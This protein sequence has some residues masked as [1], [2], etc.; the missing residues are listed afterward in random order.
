MVARRL[1]DESVQPTDFAFNN[2]NSAW[3]EKRIGLY[4]PGRQQSAVIPLLMRAQEQEGWISR[5]AIETIAEMLDMPYIRVLEVATF[6]TQFQLQPVGTNAHIQVCGTTPCMLRGAEDIRAV[7]QK[8][9]HPD[10]H[11]TNAAGTLSWEEVECMGACVNAPMIA[12]GQDT[13]EDLT[14]ERMEEIIDAFAEGR[15]DSIPPGTQ[16]DRVFAAPVEGRTTLLEEPTAERQKFVPPEPE[17]E[18]QAPPAEPQKPAAKTEPKKD[19]VKPA[20]EQEPTTAA[21]PHDVTAESAPAVK[22]PSAEAK[23]S[24]AE[25]EEEREEADDEAGADGTTSETMRE[26][27]HGSEEPGGKAD[28]GRAV[29]KPTHGEP[30]EGGSSAGVGSSVPSQAPVEGTPEVDP[31]AEEG[32]NRQLFTP[33]QGPAD[34]LK[35]INGIGPAIETKLNETGITRFSQIA[36]LSDDDVGTLNKA[37]SVQGRIE[38]DNWIEQAKVLE[39]GGAEEHR[40]VF[41]KDTKS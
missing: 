4:P 35:L 26:G 37:L 5:S 23:V 13:Y 1:A 28:T 27:A 41:G 32:G 30:A 12:I 15:G 7:C 16:I 25:A 18:E 24:E 6:Y 10:P 21:R 29:G 17:G 3:A 20:K 9:I 36:A 19:E 11:H 14:P 40:R 33:P 2:D 39:S 34:D 8:K 31:V 38:R 22:G